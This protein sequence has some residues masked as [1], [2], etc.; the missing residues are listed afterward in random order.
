MTRDAPGIGSGSGLR[1]SPRFRAPWAPITRPIKKVRAP[2]RRSAGG[3]SIPRTEGGGVGGSQWAA[4]RS[5]C[6]STHHSPWRLS[7]RPSQEKPHFCMRS[8]SWR[9]MIRSR[10]V[11]GVGLAGATDPATRRCAFP[12][13]RWPA[14]R[15]PA[16]G[17][18]GAAGLPPAEDHCP[19]AGRRAGGGTRTA[20]AASRPAPAACRRW[21]CS[22]ACGRDRWRRSRCARRCR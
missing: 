15:S 7:R 5:I 19:K 3:Q 4:I 13:T 16:P 14:P 21:R 8:F 17:Q 12:P 22:P 11:R 9:S 6:A 18:P 20:P 2:I 10:Q 1:L